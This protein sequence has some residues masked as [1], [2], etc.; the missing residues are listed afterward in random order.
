MGLAGFL[1][2][3]LAAPPPDVPLSPAATKSTLD[4]LFYTASRYRTSD[5]FKQLLEFTTRFRRYALF[6]CVLLHLQKPGVAYVATARQWWRTF[7]R[8]P[9]PGS[10]PLVIMCP[11]GPVMF[12]FD[13]AET[14]GRPLPARLLDPFETKGRKPVTEL[15]HTLANLA[16]VRI[17]YEEGDYGPGR[18]GSVAPAEGSDRVEVM[19]GRN[20]VAVPAFARMVLNKNLDTGPKYAALV[21]ELGHVFCGHLGTPDRRWWPDRHSL[22]REAREFEAESVSFLVCTRAGVDTPS[23]EYLSGY[24][25]ENYKVPEISLDR[26]LKAA[27]RIEGMGEEVLQSR[28]SGSVA[29]ALE[30]GSRRA[31]RLRPGS[32]LLRVSPEEAL[33]GDAT[34]AAGVGGTPR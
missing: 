26:V 33:N 6:N 2:R 21:H 15:R 20:A 3:V 27:G 16:G 18:A 22:P 24:F 14:E 29:Q 13:A 10:R 12:V 11:G 23:A 30:S 19:Q 25:E 8:C 1:D 5:D 9:T 28:R 32:V 31:S 34:I 17:R 4:E 7:G